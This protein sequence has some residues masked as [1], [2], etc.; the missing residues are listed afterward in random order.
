MANPLVSHI[1]LGSSIYDIL[2]ETT[3]KN[4]T[5]LS[6]L[7]YALDNTLTTPITTAKGSFTAADNVGTLSTPN[8]ITYKWTRSRNTTSFIH[9]I[10]GRVT[11]TTTNNSGGS[12]Q[13]RLRTTLPSNF[14]THTNTDFYNVG[15]W[16]FG[17][18]DQNYNDYVLLPAYGY[19]DQTY[20]DI[21]SSP[22]AIIPAGT[23]FELQ[24][25]KFLLL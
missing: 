23:H 9:S 17:N 5:N 22:T 19:L 6:D 2:D 4:L 21:Y 13:V 15:L 25:S 3:S 11:G 12:I 7:F 24:I 8:S 20:L 14:P 10:F 16:I 1:Q 18:D